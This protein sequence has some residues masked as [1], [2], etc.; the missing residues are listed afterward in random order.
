LLEYIIELGSSSDALVLDFFAG[1]GSTAHA[2]MKMNA[3]R[4]HQ[5][6]CILCT[7]N[8]YNLCEDVTYP[9]LSRVIKGYTNFKG[10]RMEG[11]FQNLSYCKVDINS[12]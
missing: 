1:S 4:M 10:K 2:V 8:E 6:R 12:I 7:N 5:R 9:R 11:V 3:E